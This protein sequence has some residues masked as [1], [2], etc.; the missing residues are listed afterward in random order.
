MIAQALRL[1]ETSI[2]RHISD[3]LNDRRLKSENG[4][5]DGMLSAEQTE[6]L[7]THLSLNL[8]STPRF[9]TV[10]RHFNARFMP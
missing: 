9:M 2:N 1:F 7:L 8:L 3:Y 5:S 10:F 4:G 6:S